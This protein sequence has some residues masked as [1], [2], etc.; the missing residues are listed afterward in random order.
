[1]RHTSYFVPQS[2]YELYHRLMKNV[3]TQNFQILGLRPS[4]R[5]A[6]FSFSVYVHA[7][8]KFLWIF[9]IETK[10]HRNEEDTV[11]VLY[12]KDG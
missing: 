1:M 7:L 4:T 9:F 5:V 8:H 6:I 10:R 2:R 12:L 11:F 3:N